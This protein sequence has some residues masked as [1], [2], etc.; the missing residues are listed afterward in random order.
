M[1][2]RF[3]NKVGDMNYVVDFDKKNVN[4]WPAAITDDT[5]RYDV[6]LPPGTI[7]HRLN[8]LNG[9]VSWFSLD[10]GIFAT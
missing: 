7:T 1:I 6:A 4:G 5:I 3:G 8:R 10:N 9:S 2:G